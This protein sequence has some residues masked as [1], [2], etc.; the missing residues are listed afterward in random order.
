[1]LQKRYVKD[2]WKTLPRNSIHVP[3]TYVMTYQP[4]SPSFA[5][6][7]MSPDRSRPRAVD[8]IELREAQRPEQAEQQVV[9]AGVLVVG[10]LDPLLQQQPTLQALLDRRRQGQP[11]VVGLHGPGGDDRVG[12]L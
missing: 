10:T 9:T 12:A 3:I 5:A 2:E 4:E 6:R 11:A 1:M 8:A 7:V